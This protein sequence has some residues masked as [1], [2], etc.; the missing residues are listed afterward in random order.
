MDSRTMTVSDRMGVEEHRN[1]DDVDY[2][3]LLNGQAFPANFMWGVAT[4]SHQIEGGNTNNWTRFEPTSK[5]GQESGIACDH[6]N[7]KE[8]DLDLIEDL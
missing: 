3:T 4:A 6:W 5:S 1:W 7:R 8:Q 2:S